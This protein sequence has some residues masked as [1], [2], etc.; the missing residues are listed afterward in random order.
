METQ[1]TSLA[2]ETI[3]LSVSD[4]TSKGLRRVKMVYVSMEADVDNKVELVKG[5]KED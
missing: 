5:E 2:K 4:G 1:A 3:S